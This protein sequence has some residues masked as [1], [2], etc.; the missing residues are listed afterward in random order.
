MKEE[1]LVSRTARQGDNLPS[2]TYALAIFR[3]IQNEAVVISIHAMMR[4]M[5]FTPHLQT[6]LQM[7]G[8]R[9]KRYS[10]KT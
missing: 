2:S 7:E 4:E 1:N 5:R 6:P 10:V 8:V 9:A 3:K